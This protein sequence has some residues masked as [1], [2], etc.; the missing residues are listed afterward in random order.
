M[1][2]A[3]GPTWRAPRGVPGCAH[4]EQTKTSYQIDTHG[5]FKATI[6]PRTEGKG[7]GRVG[8]WGRRALIS[9][10]RASRSTRRVPPASTVAGPS[11]PFARRT[12]TA[13]AQEP[14]SC[15]EE[16]PQNRGYRKHSSRHSL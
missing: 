15:D 12:D 1:V 3:Q 6:L 16:G 9:R 10:C 4:G 11:P 2:R 13:A 14:V 8:R 7:E 5:L